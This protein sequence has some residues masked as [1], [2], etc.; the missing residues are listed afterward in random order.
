MKQREHLF[1][2]EWLN[3]QVKN[4]NI[5]L[6]NLGYVRKVFNDKLVDVDNIKS[7]ESKFST[8]LKD[9]G[10]VYDYEKD[11]YF[12]PKIM[13]EWSLK[14]WNH[15][16]VSYCKGMSKKDLDEFYKEEV[17]PKNEVLLF[18]KTIRYTEK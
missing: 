15:C 9:E 16:I 17:L 12:S 3:E 10:F 2:N 18:Q 14:K 1:K 13:Y 4:G 6:E 8:S 11:A 5:Q 7:W